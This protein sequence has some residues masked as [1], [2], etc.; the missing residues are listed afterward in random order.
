MFGGD[1][2]LE[3]TSR[4]TSNQSYYL[5][6][7]YFLFYHS[8]KN[9]DQE[10]ERAIGDLK[11]ESKGI[12]STMAGPLNQAKARLVSSIIQLNLRLHQDSQSKFVK[13]AFLRLDE[14]IRDL[15]LTSEK[16]RIR[17]VSCT[18]QTLFRSFSLNKINAQKQFFR[19][20]K[21]IWF[22]VMTLKRLCTRPEMFRLCRYYSAVQ[23]ILES[24]LLRSLADFSQASLESFL[25]SLAKDFIRNFSENVHEFFPIFD[26]FITG[27]LRSPLP[28][29]LEVL[30]EIERSD[31][32]VFLVDIFRALLDSKTPSFKSFCSRVL[33]NQFQERYFLGNIMAKFAEIKSSN[34]LLISHSILTQF[35]LRLLEL[36]FHLNLNEKQDLSDFFTR[37]LSNLGALSLGSGQTSFVRLLIDYSKQEPSLLVEFVSTAVTFLKSFKESYLNFD[38]RIHLLLDLFNQ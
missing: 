15:A 34:S 36:N 22:K 12:L 6:Q 28:K 38:S 18:L 33:F 10:L 13:L 2:K 21:G 4:D 14:W 35:Y 27:L 19:M 26:D 1:E 5:K 16:C 24:V 32:K 30:G 37:V 31:S 8:R 29:V 23:A 9:N 17:E 25:I 7:R 11:S 3:V 20:Y